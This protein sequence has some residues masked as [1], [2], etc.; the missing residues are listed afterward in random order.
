MSQSPRSVRMKSRFLVDRAALLCL[1][2]LALGIAGCGSSDTTTTATRIKFHAPGGF[3]PITCPRLDSVIYSGS[4]CYGRGKSLVLTAHS[5]SSAAAA[6][7]LVFADNKITCLVSAKYPSTPRF[8]VERCEGTTAVDGAHVTAMAES[9]VLVGPHGI[10]P[11]AR[12]LPNTNTPG[13]FVLLVL[14]T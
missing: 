5:F 8:R 11:T 9:L 3:S 12:P 7:G 1:L 6:A 14:P 4:R 2:V 13:I 10:S